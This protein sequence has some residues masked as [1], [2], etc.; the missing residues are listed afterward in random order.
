LGSLANLTEMHLNDNRL[1]GSLPATLGNLGNLRYLKLKNNIISG[2]IPAALTGLSSLISLSLSCGLTSSDENVITFISGL[3]PNWLDN[4]C[5][6]T[7]TAD[8]PDPSAPGWPVTVSVTVGGGAGVPTGA[9]DITGADTNCAITLVDGAGSCEIGFSTFGPKALT[10]IYTGDSS[11]SGSWDS[12]DHSILTDPLLIW[13]APA[14]IPYGA[15]LDGTQLN[16]SAG[17][18]GA[19][20]Y[21]PPTGTLLAVGT[22]SL[23]VDF[24]PDNTAYAPASKTVSLT[25]YQTPPAVITQA[26]TTITSTGVTL[27]G[28]V[29]A[30]AD[31]STAKFEYGLTDTYGSSVNI[32]EPITGDADAPLSA[33]L[34]GL[35]PNTTYHY[36]LT[37]TNSAGTT[38][39]SDLTFT[40][41]PN[42]APTGITLTP[43]AVAENKAIGTTVG[44][45]AALDVDA[46]DTHTFTLQTGVTGCAAT[47]NASFQI[48]GTALKTKIIFDYETKRSY[49]IC[50]RVN[51]GKGGIFNQ[52]IT[53]NVTNVVDNVL[54]NG[55]FE[56]Y[57]STLTKIPL[58]WTPSKFG[59]LDGKNTAHKLGKYSVR[60]VGAP[61]KVTTLTQ[62]RYFSGFKGDKFVFSYWAKADKLP[63]VGVCQAQVSFYYKNT[64]KWIKVLKCP[65]GVTYTT[66]RQATTMSFTAPGAYTKAIVKFTYSKASGTIWFDL[67]S[68]TK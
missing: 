1:G 46:A 47:N 39:G 31:S 56:T 63:T 49:A 36:R 48:V 23:K 29:N 42:S 62:T 30:H 2:E 38:N 44:A 55:S 7:I 65:A 35:T 18:S 19:F 59:A 54:K 32:V 3:V 68:L 24:T 60:I 33:V 40:T 61:G 27:N 41:Q 5:V 58:Y 53:I 17:V 4:R 37:A 26:A 9:V 10:A 66:W 43:K 21:A 15:A 16:A 67:V 64:F 57:N 12:D 20:V 25:V 52:P 28:V 8:T 6:T 50:I 34:S 45:L 22:H 14:D 13:S 11:Y 51:D